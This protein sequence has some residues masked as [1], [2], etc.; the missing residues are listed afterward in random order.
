MK[1]KKEIYEALLA[2]ETLVN[3]S[4]LIK[5]IMDTDGRIFYSDGDECHVG[6]LETPTLW[7]IYTGPK[8]YENIPDGGVLCWGGSL[9]TRLISIVGYCHDMDYFI[10]SL[11]ERWRNATPLTIDEIQVFMNNTPK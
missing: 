10:D 9:S 2:G 7:K 1:N 6:K 4:S 3:T 5:I 11:G 8:W